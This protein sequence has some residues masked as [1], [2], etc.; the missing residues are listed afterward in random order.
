MNQL[1]EGTSP[2]QPDDYLIAQ[3]AGGGS[4]TKTYHRRKVRNIITGNNVKAALG[5][6]TETTKFLRNDGT[7]QVPTDSHGNDIAQTYLTVQSHDLNPT[8]TGKFFCG[9]KNSIIYV[10]LS[11]SYISIY[12]SKD[13]G[14]TWTHLSNTDYTYYSGTRYYGNYIYQHAPGDL[15]CSDVLIYNLSYNNRYYYTIINPN[16]ATLEFK[17]QKYL[18]EGHSSSKV[19]WNSCAMHYNDNIAAVHK[20]MNGSHYIGLIDST[21]NTLLCGY[22]KTG[23]DSYS[24]PYIGMNEIES[25]TTRKIYYYFFCDFD[26][27]TANKQRIYRIVH[28]YTYSS[29]ADTYSTST[30]TSGYSSF[31][32]MDKL[33]Q[34]GL[35]SFVY[36]PIVFADYDYA[37]E[38]YYY[39]TIG[40]VTN[41]TY[42]AITLPEKL[43]NIQ[44][45]PLV[46]DQ[47]FIIYGIGGGGEPINFLVDLKSSSYT[48]PYGDIYE[49]A[50]GIYPP[51]RTSLNVPWCYYGIT[52]INNGEYFIAHAYNTTI[53][54]I[55]G[56]WYVG[57]ENYQYARIQKNEI[58]CNGTKLGE[59]YQ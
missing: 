4:T 52:P 47:T 51:V 32:Y 31:L 11:V 53:K 48:D 13:F 25:S 37:G 33:V 36:S 6:G 40:S 21:S 12:I 42:T 22:E 39:T 29:G 58:Y 23:A 34:V 50:T 38:N 30:I 17:V 10:D 15:T 43:A 28:T 56:K 57:S 55:V 19:F 18:L 27:M 59:F 41:G 20:D 9:K 8:E 14:K 49:Q 44:I 5:T 26:N 54:S 3:Y 7:W 46:F 1:S 2:A 16:T 35:N 45:M 24:V